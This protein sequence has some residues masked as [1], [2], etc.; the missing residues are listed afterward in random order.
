MLTSLIRGTPWP[1]YVMADDSGRTNQRKDNFLHN[2]VTLGLLRAQFM[3][4]SQMKK[5]PTVFTEMS[6][7][8]EYMK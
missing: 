8:I 3:V 1:T 6:V 7:S 2:S 4:H 5:W